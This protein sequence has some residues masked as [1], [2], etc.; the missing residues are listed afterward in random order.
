MSFSQV[1]PPSVWHARASS[2]LDSEHFDVAIVGAGI[3]GI[4]A[5]LTLQRL[6]VSQKP[7]VRQISKIALIERGQIASPSSGASTR[8]AGFLMRGCADN[9]AEAVSV[10]GRA[11]AKRL[12]KLSEE[13]V[14]RL[15]NEELVPHEKRPSC[16]VATSVDEAERLALSVKMMIEDGFDVVGIDIEKFRQQMSS[17]KDSVI[18]SSFI[19]VSPGLDANKYNNLDSVLS[20]DASRYALI[21][22]N[23]GVCDPVHVLLHLKKKFDSSIVSILEDCSVQSLLLPFNNKNG[24][25]E[26]QCILP[27]SGTSGTSTCGRHIIAKQVLL[28]MNAYAPSLV[29]GLSNW[30]QPVRGQ[31]LAFACPLSDARVLYSYYV[32]HGYE[33]LRRLDNATVI[34]G[35]WRR[36]HAEREVGY[37]VCPTTEVQSGLEC[38][39]SVLLSGKIGR[40][41]GSVPMRNHVVN[42][43]WAGT[44]GFSPDHLPIASALFSKMLVPHYLDEV[45]PP[46]VEKAAVGKGMW[47][48]R[49]WFCGAFTGHG[50]SLGFVTAELTVKAMITGAVELNSSFGSSRLLKKTGKL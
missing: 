11:E 39:A 6:I 35:G 26:L 41:T 40:P 21:N 31:M 3:A 49:V 38:A 45:Y 34:I 18:P 24:S 12:W 19:T 9:Y 2:T 14:S 43:R 44:M 36:R 47:D 17:S 32:N 42:H 48:T 10:F 20:S 22:P 5:A 23:D 1:C 28:C 37:D 27:S 33:Y 46:D 30:V 15:M 13:N 29:P 4:S 7:S 50:M 16:L 8:N 25:V